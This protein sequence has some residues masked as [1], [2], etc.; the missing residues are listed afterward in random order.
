MKK[1]SRR[2]YNSP[3][4][5][6]A[7]LATRKA[8]LDAAAGLF[9]D[10]GYAGTSLAAVAEKAEVSLA[11]VKLVAQTKATLLLELARAQA[12]GD[13]DATALNER[14]WWREMLS[15][16]DP[17]ELV[18][19]WVA[20]TRSVLE[21]QAA[22]FEV[23]WQAAPGEPVIAQVERKGSAGRREDFRGVIKSLSELGALRDGLTTEAA[24]D[25]AWVLNSPLV[26]RLFARCGWTP[27]QWE[28]WLA[29]ALATQLLDAKP[30]KAT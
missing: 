12:R 11:T 28:K 18:R 1:V 22:L 27:D 25:I 4:R 30:P 10:R 21:R 5:E 17:V 13:A 3:R 23:V 9:L 7:A 6:A 19:R 26:F 24:V 8:V 20:L 2:S 16:R 15:D 14:S 29:G